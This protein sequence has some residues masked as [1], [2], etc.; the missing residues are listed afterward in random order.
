M[1]DLQNEGEFESGDVERARAERF[2]DSILPRERVIK[3]LD[4]K[5]GEQRFEIRKPAY[6][7]GVDVL[8]AESEGVVPMPM[9]TASWTSNGSRSRARSTTSFFA[10]IF[11]NMPA[12][13]SLFSR[14]FGKG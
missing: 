13:L 5:A 6:V 4:I 3:V 11:S 14:S 12:T 2:V 10:S 1:K 8:Q 7:V 9:S